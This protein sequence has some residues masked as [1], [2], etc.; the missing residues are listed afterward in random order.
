M[1][2]PYKNCLDYGQ[3]HAAAIVARI[4]TEGMVT[5]SPPELAA[6]LAAAWSDGYGAAMTQAS[7]IVDN[8]GRFIEQQTT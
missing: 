1:S 3:R 4:G 6:M 8:V 5:L 2:E 7:A